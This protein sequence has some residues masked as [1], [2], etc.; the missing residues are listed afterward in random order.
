M[1]ITEAKK[2]AHLSETR[3]SSDGSSASSVEDDQ[4]FK[5]LKDQNHI[6]TTDSAIDI[7]ME[8]LSYLSDKQKDIMS[9]TRFPHVKH[10]FLKF[11]TIIPSSAPVE[12]LFSTGGQILIPR[13]NRLSDDVFEAFLMCKTN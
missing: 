11:N 3:I 6:E 8:V 13:R 12:R 1:L 9:L 5:F 7:N 4:F 10:L 2:C